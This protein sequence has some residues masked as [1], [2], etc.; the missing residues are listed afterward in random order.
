MTGARVCQRADDGE[1]VSQSC[2]FWQQIG[3][4]HADGASGY[5][6]EWAAV[7]GW[8]VWFW[9][10]SFEVACPAAQP[11]QNDRSVVRRL[12]RVFGPKANELWQ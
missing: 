11:N 12:G 4:L 5:G 8:G 6:L 7:F 3:H 9:V 1:F 2:L 10:V